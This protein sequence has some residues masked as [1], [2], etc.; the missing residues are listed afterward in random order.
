MKIGLEELQCT[1][2]N[3]GVSDVTPT[4]SNCREFLRIHKWDDVHNCQGNGCMRSRGSNQKGNLKKFE[5]AG[6]YHCHSC[7]WKV[8]QVKQSCC[9]NVQ[10]V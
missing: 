4:L 7:C 8:V 1:V 10:R 5:Q 9:K 6:V 3:Q 2:A